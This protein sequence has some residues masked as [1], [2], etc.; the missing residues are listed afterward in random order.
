MAKKKTD[1]LT[2]VES[3]IKEIKPTQDFVCKRDHSQWRAA[4]QAAINV[5]RPNRK[6]LYDIYEFTTSID[7]MGSGIIERTMLEI[8]QKKFRLVDSKGNEN[9]E[10]TNILEATWFKDFMRHALE[11]RYWGHS[12]IELGNIIMVDNTMA[13]DEVTLIPRRHVVPELGVVVRNIS[14]DY[15][16]GI[17]YRDNVWVVECGRKT[18]LGI[19]LK[20][21]PHV[22][23]K[24]HCQIF[25]D[26]L[27]ERFGIPIIY[28]TTS[29][30]NPNNIDDLQNALS[31]GGA[32]QWGILPTGTTLQIVETAKGD[33][34]QV[35]DKR[36]ERANKEISIALAGQTMV[37]D[38]GSSRSQGEVHE[39]G[40]EKIVWQM[41]DMLKDTINNSLL[42]RMDRL[43]FPVAGYR[44]DWNDSYDYSPEEI[45]KVEQMLISGGYEIN[46]KYFIDKYGIPITGKTTQQL[47]SANETPSAKNFFD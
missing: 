41:A 30:Q 10:Q 16:N 28:A 33:I 12:L 2:R 32:N 43:G 21:T 23:S 1:T 29:T 31:G 8:M 38:N 40:F 25:W 20:T 14:D 15:K 35:Y 47:N 5:S 13:F 39:R 44:F 22:M 34:F 4:H 9:Q 46:N 26:D 11:A 6:P 19:F 36:I 17:P 24:K 27:G 45:Y 18:D 37:F 7:T 3:I 42:P